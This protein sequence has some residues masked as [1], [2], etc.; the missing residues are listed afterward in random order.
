MLL[1][2]CHQS[3]RIEQCCGA[4]LV[5][6]PAVVACSGRD[7][8]ADLKLSFLRQTSNGQ[9]ESLLYKN[10]QREPLS[11]S[12]PSVFASP[13]ATVSPANL[14]NLAP[15]SQ[16]YVCLRLLD[17]RSSQR[18]C[19]LCRRTRCE[20]YQT[21]RTNHRRYVRRLH[22]LIF[23]KLPPF[24]RYRRGSS[25]CISYHF[26]HASPWQSFLTQTPRF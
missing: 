5:V 22:R 20:C 15:S 14:I 18:R 16:H 19:C 7:S 3:R 26:T 1:S 24:L 10:L 4:M 11:S 6:C 8:D 21:R 2:V 12:T 17:Y 25:T 13:T 9:A 23:C